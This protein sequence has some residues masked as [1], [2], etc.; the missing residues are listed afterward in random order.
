MVIALLLFSNWS[1]ICILASMASL[2][3]TF[4]SLSSFLK[5]S[6]LRYFLFCFSMKGSTRAVISLLT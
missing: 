1:R 4:D 6:Y 3:N 2:V 5:S